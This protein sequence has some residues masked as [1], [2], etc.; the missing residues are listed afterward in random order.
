M[1]RI[2]QEGRKEVRE[3]GEEELKTYTTKEIE[4][5]CRLFLQD[6]FNDESEIQAI[7]PDG[8]EIIWG[9]KMGKEITKHW[10]K[11]KK[12]LEK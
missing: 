7:S 5:A 2:Y 1:A 3:I 4:R 8:K 12:Y 9:G 11:I 10:L 6:A